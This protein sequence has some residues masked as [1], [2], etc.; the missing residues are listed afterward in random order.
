LS[1]SQQ[2]APVPDGA[3]QRVEGVK[4]LPSVTVSTTSPLAVSNWIHGDPSFLK[5]RELI[6]VI[7]PDLTVTDRKMLDAMLAHA[8]DAFLSSVYAQESQP[9]TRI[10]A[11]LATDIKRA[12][13]WEGHKSNKTLLAA[14]KKLQGAVITIGYFAPG[15]DNL[16]HL[17][18]SL[19]T[20][21]DVP[22]NQGIV[23][24]RFSPELEKLMSVRGER[25]LVQLKVLAKLT[26]GYSHRLYQLLCAN[27]DRDTFSWTVEV[28]DLR[29]VLNAAATSYDSWAAFERRVLKIA[30]DEINQH[31]AF[32]VRYEL[33]A[34]EKT[35]RRTHVTFI[36]EGP[37]AALPPPEMMP[38]PSDQSGQLVLDLPFL[39][40]DSEQIP[41]LLKRR[42]NVPT[43]QR[44]REHFGETVPL[45]AL[46]SLWAEWCARYE[47]KVDRPA[48]IFERWLTT[49]FGDLVLA[50]QQGAQP[51]WSI[52]LSRDLDH[53]KYRV[54]FSLSNMVAQQ[55]QRWLS[56]AKRK[57]SEGHPRS[58]LKLS[59]VDPTYFHQWVPLIIEEFAQANPI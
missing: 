1:P 35:R 4:S 30:V 54:M 32:C 12:M 33:V 39:E 58:G 27:T 22:E 50:G 17:N 18:I 42:I 25:F 34:D 28:S 24:W 37:S 49:L 48:R 59:S 5:V 20:L 45:D 57:M 41:T 7:D 56:L 3:G 38:R 52:V 16:R 47:V 15:D 26:S 21:S 10:F 8:S 43:R 19:I 36:V 13:G 53:P 11:A 9:G 29:K 23:Y 40:G 6:E 2:I 31:A 46:I 51:D 44:L 55:R 14:A